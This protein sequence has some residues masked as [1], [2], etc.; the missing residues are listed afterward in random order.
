MSKSTP[1]SQLPNIILN[2]PQRQVQL[3]APQIQDSDEIIQ[4]TLSQLNAQQPVVTQQSN[5]VMET[6]QYEPS[7][8]DQYIAPTPQPVVQNDTQMVW[9]DNVQF[10][11]TIAVLHILL[12][13]VPIENILSQ[14][15]NIGKIPYAGIILKG[16]LMFVMVI[17]LQ[18]VL[19]I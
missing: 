11:I 7:S 5:P 1:I 2:D 3:Q 15:V 18:K 4:E 10:A 8:Y 13:A 17:L 16:F 14:Y 9:N 12:T 6:Y 19:K